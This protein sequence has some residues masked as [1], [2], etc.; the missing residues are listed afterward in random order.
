MAAARAGENSV[1]IKHRLRN[2][3]VRMRNV[4]VSKTDRTGGGLDRPHGRHTGKRRTPAPVL[5]AGNTPEPLRSAQGGRAQMWIE[6]V[7]KRTFVIAHHHG[8]EASLKPPGLTPRGS[9]PEAKHPLG[10]AQRSRW[11]SRK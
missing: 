8:F 5:G 7:Q 4:R 10:A 11:L 6:P 2:G 1:S 9:R 3:P